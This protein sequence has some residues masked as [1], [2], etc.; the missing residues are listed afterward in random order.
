MKPVSDPRGENAA[1]RR[2]VIEP[3]NDA[4]SAGSRQPAAASSAAVRDDSED[5]TQLALHCG[6]NIDDVEHDDDDAAGGLGVFLKATY[7]SAHGQRDYRLYRPAGYAHGDRALPLVVMLHGCAHTPENFALGTRM[8]VLADRFG[9]LVAYPRQPMKE[10]RAK[11]WN[12]Y[13]PDHQKPDEGEP[14]ILAGIVREIASTHR[15]D[16][17]RI[18][19]AGLSAGASMAAVL[20]F[21]Y[22]DLFRAIGVHSGTP[23]LSAH[24]VPSAL[25]TLRGHG[26]HKSAPVSQPSR[27]DVPMIVFQ[28]DHDRVVAP[29]NADALVRQA[30][31]D[32]LHATVEEGRVPDGHAYTRE[33]FTDAAGQPRIERWTVHGAGHA[34]SGGSKEGIYMD[35]AGP[36]A[37]LEMVRFFLRTGALRAGGT[38]L[39]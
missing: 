31:N 4:P 37:S 25:A 12:W 35:P 5:E 24:S 36:D 16:A 1:A 18:F 34:W 30:M 23:Y 28:G 20:G 26:F 27:L 14:A 7:A 9:F 8:N 15:V 17:D 32:P 13:R 3:V 21:T 6:S 38:A 29:I 39:H 22:P 19:V 2:A 33:V 11:C 10:S